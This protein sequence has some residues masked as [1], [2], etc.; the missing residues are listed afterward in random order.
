MQTANS[1]LDSQHIHCSRWPDPRGRNPTTSAFDAWFFDSKVV[2]DAGVPLVVYRG[3]H[4]KT[5][6]GDLQT[7]L[8]T[9]TFT[10][11]PAVAS[12]YASQPND[13][14]M[15]SVAEQPRVIPA[16]LSIKNPLFNKSD[17]PFVDLSEIAMKLKSP[18]FAMHMALKHAAHIEN[19]NNWEEIGASS[20]KSFLHFEPEGINRLYVDAYVLLDDP[21]FIEFARESGFDG[22]IHLGNGESALELEYRVFDKKQVWSAIGNS[23]ENFDRKPVTGAAVEGRSMKKPRRRP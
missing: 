14:K 11:S 8:G 4:G 1:L 5:A 9:Y 16:Y 21:E 17:D 13:Y 12:A 18:A 7:A 22:A 15:G 3:E 2:D 23:A 10:R 6:D 20:V 19:T